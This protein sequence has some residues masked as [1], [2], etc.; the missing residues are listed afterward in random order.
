[1]TT[2][3]LQQT[4]KTLTDALK[5]TKAAYYKGTPGVTYE[6]MRDAAARLLTFRGLYERAT[7]RPV[8]SKATPK[9]VASL[10]RSSL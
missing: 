4:I 5:A 2:E 9:A 7:G 1:M 6:D 10:L 3:Q 8:R